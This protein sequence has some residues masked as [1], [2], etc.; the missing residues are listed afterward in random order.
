MT[1]VPMGVYL[2]KF[3]DGWRIVHTSEDRIKRILYLLRGK[4]SQ[5]VLKECFKGSPLFKTYMGVARYGWKLQKKIEKEGGILEY[6]A[7]II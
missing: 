3:K 1:R 7:R 5:K 4:D 2:H 6:G